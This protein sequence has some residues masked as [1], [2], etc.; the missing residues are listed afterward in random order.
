MRY[1]AGAALGTVVG[2]CLWAVVRIVDAVE[3]ALERACA[4]L[5]ERDPR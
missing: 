2:A 4:D 5:A 1:A 3:T